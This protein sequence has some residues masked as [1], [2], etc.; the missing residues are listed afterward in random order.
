MEAEPRLCSYEPTTLGWTKDND[1][2]GFVDFTISVRYQLLPLYFTRFQDQYLGR[3]FP[4]L[5]ERSAFYLAFT[6]RFGQ[7]LGTRDSSPVVGKRFNPKLFYRYWTDD[8]LTLDDEHASHIDVAFA[9]ESNGQSIDSL[10]EYQA[11]VSTTQD[12]AAVNDQLS[13]GWDYFEVLW[14]RNIE[15]IEVKGERNL[16]TYVRLKY[17]LSHGPLQGT[18]EE[19]VP[20]EENPEG[21]KRS[22]VNGVSGMIKYVRKGEWGSF[23]DL[24]LSALYETGYRKP[25]R[26]G[27]YRYEIGSKL[28]QLPVSVWWQNGF[29]SDLAQYYKRV[30]SYGA[31]IEIGSF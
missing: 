29:N 9:H 20:W 7:Y 10:E 25:F 4:G 3:Y 15:A 22:F 8:D 28:W 31:Q 23:Q 12:K 13:R 27:T 14:K 30:T 26:F 21:K 18:A 17:F 16:Y 11:A 6:G 24:K 19:Y 5:G 1:D 2:N